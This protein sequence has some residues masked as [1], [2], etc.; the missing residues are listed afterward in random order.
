M[1]PE[2]LWT[3]IGRLRRERDDDPDTMLVCDVLARRLLDALKP[4]LLP[5]AIMTAIGCPVCKARRKTKSRAM[6]RYRYRK[7]RASHDAERIERTD[8]PAG[9][10][11]V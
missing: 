6:L 5:D 9:P 7:W 2:S 10:V 11:T 4:P 8:H 3:V 1:E